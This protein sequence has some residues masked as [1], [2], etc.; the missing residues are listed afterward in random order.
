M[1]YHIPLAFQCICGRSNEGGEDGDREEGSEIPGGWE[2]VEITWPLVCR[3]LGSVWG[4]G[5]VPEG[6]GGTIC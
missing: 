4:V 2:R 3:G 6:D 5:G 1:I